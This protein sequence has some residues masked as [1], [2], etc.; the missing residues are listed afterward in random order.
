MVVLLTH[1][2]WY[3]LRSHESWLHFT[4][5]GLQWLH[6]TGAADKFVISNVTFLLDSVYQN[7]Q[8]RLIF[9]W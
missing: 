1:F 2:I 6:F 5:Y 3:G 8:N 9:D 4:R 7:Y